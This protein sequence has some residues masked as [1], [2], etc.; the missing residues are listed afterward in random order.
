MTY[1]Y[2]RIG[3]EERSRFREEEIREE[4]GVDGGIYYD[5]I[6]ARG[7]IAPNFWDMI[8]KAH[9]YDTIVVRSVANLGLTN[10][11]LYE[12][13]AIAKRRH[14]KVYAK[15]EGAELTSAEVMKVLGGVKEVNKQNQ[16]KGIKRAKERGV[17]FGREIVYATDEKKVNRV[18]LEYDRQMLSWRDAADK[19]GIEKKSTFFY[20]YN[21]WER[22]TGR[23]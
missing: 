14:I 10:N 23:K 18:M 20:R 17:K 7:S 21:K 22:E 16:A 11:A 15:E 8:K 19:L 1:G 12:L 4:L 3:I 2:V 5:I 13:L 9:K 6:V